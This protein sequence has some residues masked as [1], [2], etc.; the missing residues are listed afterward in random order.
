MYR[1]E[2]ENEAHEE[3][4]LRQFLWNPLSVAG[5]MLSRS[6]VAEMLGNNGY[7]ISAVIGLPDYTGSGYTP[8]G[9]GR[10]TSMIECKSSHNLLVPNDFDK[11]QSRYNAAVTQQMDEGN[12]EYSQDWSHIC[13]PFGRLFAYMLDNGVRFGA[14]CSASKTYFVFF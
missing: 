6:D 11:L 9:G 13:H 1:I 14:L 10:I 8:G 5:L 12:E 3:V 4:F 2:V 7:R